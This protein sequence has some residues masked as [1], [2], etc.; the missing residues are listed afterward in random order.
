[1][2]TQPKV[3]DRFINGKVKGF[4]SVL[5]NYVREV[6]V[7]GEV[8]LARLRWLSD[9]LDDV[10]KMWIMWTSLWIRWDIYVGNFGWWRG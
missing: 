7:L 1:M 4:I 5:F 10:W 3:M 8:G 2:F 6:L 9:I